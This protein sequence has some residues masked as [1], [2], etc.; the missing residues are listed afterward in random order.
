LLAAALAVSACTVG[1]DY[2]RPKSDLPETW[3][4]EMLDQAGDTAD[5]GSWWQR[6]EDPTLTRLVEQALDRNLDIQAQAARVRQARAALGL[7]EAEQYP[8]V[9]LQADVARQRASEH[10]ISAGGGDTFDTFSLAGSLNYELDLWGRVAREEE[11]ARARLF[12]SLFT[13]EAVRLNVVTDIVTT[14]YNLRASERQLRIAR[15][16]VQSREQTLQLEQARR[17]AGAIA[18]LPV[19]QAQ[20]ELETTRSQIPPLQ[21]QVRRQRTALAILV[22]ATPREIVERIDTS[23]PALGQARMP[24]EMPDVLPSELLERRPDIRAAEATLAAANADIGVAK[25]QWYPSVNLAGLLGVDAIEGDDLFEAGARTWSVGGSLLQ[26]LLYFG[27]IEASVE[28]AEAAR[29][30]AT[31]SYRRTVR[32]AFQEVDD[33]LA[34]L[35]AANQ[36]L[37]ARQRQVDALRDTLDLAR[38]RYEGGFTSFINVLDAQRGLL[39]AQLALAEA[40]RDRLTAMAT[41]YKALG[42]GWSDK[43]SLTGSDRSK[44]GE[45]SLGVNS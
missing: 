37:G 30:R 45:T 33:A 2:E 27:R 34:A 12:G 3:Q 42:G 32:T 15:E 40:G 14:Y 36:R 16:T 4:S 10:G 19:R 25:S 35:S 44:D 41:L 18:S 20:A 23:G 13:K 28:S 9:D 24:A 6:Y 38:R 26:P 11:A 31:M 29:E 22:G 8:T 17:D 43:R 7:A 5:Y 1:P 21:D 39:D